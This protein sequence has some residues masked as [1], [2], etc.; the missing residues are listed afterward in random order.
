MLSTSVDCQIKQFENGKH[1]KKSYSISFKFQHSKQKI[2]AAF[3]ANRN[4]YD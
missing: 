4:N 1:D 3:N 2:H